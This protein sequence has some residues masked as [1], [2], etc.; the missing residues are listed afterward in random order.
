MIIVKHHPNVY[1]FID[2]L[3]SEQART[4]TCNEQFIAGQEPKSQSRKVKSVNFRINRIVYDYVNHP[5][6]EFLCGIAM[7]L[8]Y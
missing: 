7:D 8:K 3:K 1:E 6:L 5:V 4:D 2:R